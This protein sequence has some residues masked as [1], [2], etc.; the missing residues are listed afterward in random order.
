[1]PNN[2]QQVPWYRPGPEFKATDA[3]KDFFVLIALT[4]VAGGINALI[5]LLEG[6]PEL[7]PPEYI[8]YTGLIIA[9]LHAIYTTIINYKNGL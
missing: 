4:F 6:S 3:I 9:V 1:M 5:I 8:A 7:I 2:I